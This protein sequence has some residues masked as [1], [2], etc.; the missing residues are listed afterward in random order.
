VSELNSDT[1]E[2]EVLSILHSFNLLFNNHL[3]ISQLAVMKIFILNSTMKT[4]TY[5]P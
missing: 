3:K 5:K 4:S 1:K 2:P